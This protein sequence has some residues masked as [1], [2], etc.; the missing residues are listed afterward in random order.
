[1]KVL[2][3]RERGYERSFEANDGYNK[4]MQALGAKLG[5]KPICNLAK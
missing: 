2:N 4:A 5:A 3:Q 1:M